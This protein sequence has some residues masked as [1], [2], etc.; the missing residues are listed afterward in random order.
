MKNRIGTLAA[1]AS[2]RPF[3]ALARYAR[4]RRAQ[5]ENQIAEHLARVDYETPE[6]RRI[7]RETW[8]SERA[9]PWWLRWAI[10]VIDLRIEIEIDFWRRMDQG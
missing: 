6:F 3:A 2:R 10:P 5:D 9:L 4:A 1:P 7:N 8:E